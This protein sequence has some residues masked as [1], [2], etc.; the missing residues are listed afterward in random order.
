M[1]EASTIWP[2][3]VQLLVEPP[4]V[5]GGQPVRV[6]FDADARSRADRVRSTDCAGRAPDWRCR[7]R[8]TR[9][10]SRSWRCA[11]PGADRPSGSAAPSS[12][13]PSRTSTGRSRS[14]T[15]RSRSASTCS[16]ARTAGWRRAS[17]RPSRSS[18]GR[19]A[20]RIPIVRNA[21]PSSSPERSPKS[22]GRNPAPCGASCGG[23]NRTGLPRHRCSGRAPPP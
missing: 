2:N 23:R 11:A 22:A 9:R 10:C 1:P 8:S 4:A 6:V 3:V 20:R 16:P 14:R 17:S 12:R 21:A 18:A 7:G 13:P 5:E 15:C 19:G